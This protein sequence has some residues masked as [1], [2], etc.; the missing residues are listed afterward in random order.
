MDPSPQTRGRSWARRWVA[1]KGLEVGAEVKPSGRR[2]PQ[3][4]ALMQDRG[5]LRGPQLEMVEVR[6]KNDPSGDCSR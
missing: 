1:K 2:M 6:I 5:F 4:N 3:E